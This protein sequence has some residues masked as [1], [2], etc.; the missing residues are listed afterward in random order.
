MS[1][2]KR[3]LGKDG[4]VAY[5]SGEYARRKLDFIDYYCPT[6]IDVTKK[7]MKRVYL[8]LFA[9]PGLNVLKPKMEEVEGGAL[10]VLSSR[11]FYNP[12]VSFT[13]AHLVNR[14]SEHKRALETRIEGLKKSGRC[15]VPSGDI[16]N[17]LGNSNELIATLMKQLHPK[18]YILV[19]ADIEAP[20]QLPWSTVHALKGAGHESVDLYMLFPLEMGLNRLTDYNGM[21]D[22]NAEIFSSFYGC[23]DW[24]QIVGNR[25]TESRS[26]ETKQLLEDLYLRRLRSQWEMAVKV[27]DVRLRGR[28]GLYRMLFATNN[29]SGQEIATWARKKIDRESQGS[30]F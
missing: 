20:R 21:T 24:K 29:K 30:L 22:G 9:G 25:V 10:R 17:H 13:H 1:K 27:M 4:L 12:G 16:H 2:P 23:D 3:V 26:G 6:A 28:R 14:D 7:K 8:D 15:M 18:D 5:S 19:F 11:G